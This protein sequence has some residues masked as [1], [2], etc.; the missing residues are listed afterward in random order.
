MLCLG[1]FWVTPV[2]DSEVMRGFIDD[3][4][5]SERNLSV[6]FHVNT[7]RGQ[8]YLSEYQN[9]YQSYRWEYIDPLTREDYYIR[10]DF[11]ATESLSDFWA[12]FFTEEEIDEHIPK[13]V[14]KY[15]CVD[16]E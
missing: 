5:S 15:K 13:I 3:C 7:G 8:E 14:A 10:P 16:T 12:A 4:N 11:N 6:L 2:F 1:Q 9:G